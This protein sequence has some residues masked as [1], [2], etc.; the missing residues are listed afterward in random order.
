MVYIQKWV[1]FNTLGYIVVGH[2]DWRPYLETDATINIIIIFMWHVQ[3]GSKEM[4]GDTGFYNML[5]QVLE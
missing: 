2:N 3:Q 1:A 5:E 4:N